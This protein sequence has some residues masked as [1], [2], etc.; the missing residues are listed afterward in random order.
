MGYLDELQGAG[1]I[2]RGDTGWLLSRSLDSTDLLQL[3]QRGQYRLPLRPRELVRE[4]GLGLPEALLAM[5][6]ELAVALQT[7][8]GHTLA[9]VYPPPAPSN[10]V[11]A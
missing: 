4:L 7:G 2:Q 3:Y 5:L 9:Q 8:L 6:V 11:S 1:L 10:E